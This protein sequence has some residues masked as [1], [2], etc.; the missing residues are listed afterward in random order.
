VTH[1]SS[2]GEFVLNFG[3][4]SEGTNRISVANEGYGGNRAAGN[5]VA[6]VG[7]RGMELWQQGRLTKKYSGSPTRPDMSAFTLSLG[8]GGSNDLVIYDYV[9]VW[10]RQLTPQEINLLAET[11]GMAFLMPETV[12]SMEIVPTGPQEYLKTVTDAMTIVQS[13]G[14]EIPTSVVDTLSMLSGTDVPPQGVVDTL[15]IVDNVF[16]ILE[17]FPG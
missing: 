4:S 5:F 10:N 3:G 15:S 9:L 13:P 1:A 17:I 2:T 14:R 16:D 6:T 12:K 7:G 11:E 8:D